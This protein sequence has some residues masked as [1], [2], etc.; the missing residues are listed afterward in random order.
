MQTFLGE[1]AADLYAKHG[2]GISSLTVVFPNRRATRFFALELAKIIDRPIFQPT[3]ASIDD[4][5]QQKTGLILAHE[6]TLIAR[7]WTLYNQHVEGAKENFDAF[8]SWGKML[9]VDF[10]TIDKYMIDPR[11]LYANMDDLQ[12]ME[13]FLGDE[14]PERELVKGFWENIKKSQKTGSKHFSSFQNI[15]NRLADLYESYTHALKGEGLAYSGMIYR[16]AAEAFVSQSKQEQNLEPTH[17]VFV[18]FNALNRCEQTILCCL[19]EQGSASFYFD[20]DAYFFDDKHQEAGLFLR[21][22]VRRLSLEYTAPSNFAKTKNIEVIASPNDIMQCGALSVALNET[23]ERQGYLAHE[24]AVILTDESLLPIALHNIPSAISQINVTMGAPLV[25]SAPYLFFQRV[26]SLEARRNEQGYYYQDVLLCLGH[27]YLSS[28]STRKLLSHLSKNQYLYIPASKLLSELPEHFNLL[29]KPEPLQAAEL[30]AYYTEVVEHFVLPALTGDTHQDDQSGYA[31]M[32]V[33]NLRRMA[34]ILT[35]SDVEVSKNLLHSLLKKINTDSRIPYDGDPLQGLQVMG[36]LESRCLDFKNVIMLSL[37]D[38]NFPGVSPSPSFIPMNLR[39]GFSLP[40]QREVGAM[41]SYYFY[42]LIQRTENLTLIYSTSQRGSATGEQSRFISQL[43]YESPH[44]LHYRNV[45]LSVQSQ[46]AAQSIEVSKTSDLLQILMQKTY[47]PSALRV[48]LNCPLQFYF[49]RVAKIDVQQSRSGEIAANQSGSILHRA[50]E[51]LY[52]DLLGKTVSSTTFSDIA[53]DKEAILSAITIAIEEVLGDSSA[54]PEL[55]VSLNHLRRLLLGQINAIL[56]VDAADENLLKIEKL[57]EKLSLNL[58]V[59]GAEIKIGG[60]ADRIDRL[61]DGKPRILD[62]KSGD[63]EHAF[64]GLESLFVNCDDAGKYR[65][66]NANA[67][68]GLI[69]SLALGG[70]AAVGVYSLSR[71]SKNDQT[72]YLFDK[73]TDREIM[74][75]NADYAEELKRLLVG[76]FSELFDLQTPFKQSPFE[77]SCTYCDYCSICSR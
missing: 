63:M 1:V 25:Q 67:L 57:E 47:S 54:A 48:Y 50:I 74:D 49:Q 44:T 29:F 45:D 10:D 24:T 18:G 43:E 34:D 26:I 41:W 30:V 6:L 62:Y 22:N 11:K 35:T 55:Q 66:P 60:I 27:S 21:D 13:E 65:A 58:Q 69:Y 59:D 15:W 3:F 70:E 51:E 76:L 12:Q 46:G 75:L 68:Q 9:L 7:L 38:E 40:T 20:S 37:S 28:H 2:E 61:K 4:L 32:M 39:Q 71:M 42:R 53:K 33:E 23:L 16:E 36:I 56:E 64:A 77:Q 52:K 72:V 14:Y 31:L 73:E 8:Y 17:Y 5:V 19:E